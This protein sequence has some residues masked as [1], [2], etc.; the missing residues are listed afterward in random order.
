MVNWLRYRQRVLRLYVSTSDKKIVFD[1]YG[2]KK[3]KRVYIRTKSNK[4][5]NILEH[6]HAK[7]MMQ[8]VNY[9]TFKTKK[10]NLH[11][12]STKSKMNIQNYTTSLNHKVGTGI[13]TLHTTVCSCRL[14]NGVGIYTLHSGYLHT[15][16]YSGYL[17]TTH[18]SVQLQ[19]GEWSGQWVSTHYTVGIY[20]LHTTQ[21]VPTNCVAVEWR[22]GGSIV[23]PAKISFVFSAEKSQRKI[24]GGQAVPQN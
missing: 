10:D 18:Y 7:V 11:F 8:I 14:Q 22:Y 24:I 23:L 5:C 19:N 4:F 3:R 20:T 2:F 13:Y 1:T 12:V 6:I 21:W 15:T 9:R 17:H 16:L